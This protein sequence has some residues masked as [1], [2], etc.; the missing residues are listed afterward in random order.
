MLILGF[1]SLDEIKTDII[2]FAYLIDAPKYIIPTFGYSEDF[3]KP[4]IEVDGRGYH[5]VVVERGAELSRKT[6]TAF[7]ELL[8]WVFDGITFEMATEYEMKNRN[9]KQDFRRILFEKQVELLRT[10]NPEFAERK[11]S[12]IEH[13]LEI[14]PFK[15]ETM[16]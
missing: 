16:K 8:Y 7:N 15:D 2:A 11:K 1:K 10:V 9:A 5:Y 13:I 14:N 3:A 6:T 4:H 12:E